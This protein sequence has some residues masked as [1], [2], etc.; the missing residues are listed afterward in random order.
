[1]ERLHI[2]VQ[3]PD[4][5]S[6]GYL[7]RGTMN[8]EWLL[9]LHDISNVKWETKTSFEFGVYAHGKFKNWFGRK[10]DPDRAWK[11]CFARNGCAL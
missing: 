2:V 7:A 5:Y 3:L 1:M 10:P 9:P 4:S 11:D 8:L 6:S